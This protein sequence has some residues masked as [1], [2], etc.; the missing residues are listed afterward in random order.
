MQAARKALME[1]VSSVI[2]DEII[3]EVVVEEAHKTASL[4]YGYVFVMLYLRYIISY[5]VLITK[6][7]Y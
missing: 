6:R 5:N 2:I 3:N 7:Q 4:A 1:R